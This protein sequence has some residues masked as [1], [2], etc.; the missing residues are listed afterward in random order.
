VIDETMTINPSDQFVGKV[1]RLAFIE[2]DLLALVQMNF[3]IIDNPVAAASRLLFAFALLEQFD[4]RSQFHALAT[5][6]FWSLR[7]A[8]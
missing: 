1:L 5:T 8:V 6:K 4:T 2:G 7:L 3:Q